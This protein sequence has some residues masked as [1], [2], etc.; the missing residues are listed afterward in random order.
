M[1]W[2]CRLA[3]APVLLVLWAAG[4]A[5]A[6]AA[7]PGANGRLSFDA[8]GARGKHLRTS[9]LPGRR[10]RVIARFAPLPVGLDY[11]SGV[12]QWN[13]SGDR[14][15]YQRIGTGFEIVAPGGGQRRTIETSLLWPGWSP[16]GRQIVAVDATTWPNSLVR[17]RADGSRLRRI[18]TLRVN[19]L[20]VPR[21]SPS[22]RWILFQ[23]GAPDGVF[24]WR[25]RP[26]GSGARR[27]AR[28]TWH[29]WAPTGRRFAYAEGREV[30]SM[31][32]DGSGRRLLS[33]GPPNT[34]VAG[35]AW[36]PDGRRIVFVRQRPADAHH[37]STVMTIRADGG[38]ARRQFGGT[39]FIGTIDWQPLP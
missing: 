18:A 28:G 5:P 10:Q 9:T 21:W 24:I 34:A 20:A 26:D 7:W 22:G 32:P 1:R 4:A 17:M 8:I 39:R 12:P 23:E 30:W 3:A 19:G 2:P 29:S 35:V 6:P 14:I 31:R 27:L 38:R 13:P 15:L 36:S 25:I 16:D 37:T 11:Q 33:R